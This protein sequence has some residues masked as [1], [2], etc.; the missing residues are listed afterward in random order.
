MRLTT[1]VRPLALAL[2]ALVLAACGSQP[3]QVALGGTVAADTASQRPTVE[4]PW[5]TVKTFPR[6]E[7]A[8]PPQAADVAF[9]RDMIAHHRQAIE[10]SENVRRHPALDERVNASARFIIQDQRNEITTMTAW[11]RAWQQETGTSA[12]H[13]HAAGSM[14]GMIAQKSVDE[15]AT[16]APPEAQVAFLRAMIEHHEG[17]VTMSQDYLPVQSNAFVH[18]TAT[19]IIAEQTT[20]IRYMEGLVREW[21]ETD[22][23]R[24]CPAG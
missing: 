17:A 8:E 7:K 1:L 21:C 22:G 14:P 20:E 24:T 11:L 18:S 6:L 10:L 4:R 15:I 23:P 16:L 3:Q 12:E 9:V 19:H 5:G 13:E 2:T